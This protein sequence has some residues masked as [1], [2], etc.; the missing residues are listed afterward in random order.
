M[1]VLLNGFGKI[2][3]AAVLVE[4]GGECLGVDMVL[5]GAGGHMDQVHIVLNDLGKLNAVLQ[6]HAA[7][8][9]LGAGH[10]VLNQ[11]VV[12]ADLLDLFTYHNGE[13]GAVCHASAAFVG[14]VV[15][16]GGDELVQQP[17]VTAVEVDHLEAQGLGNPCHLSPLL[18]GLLHHLYGHFLHL[19]AVVTDIGGG[20]DGVLMTGNGVGMVH[21]ANMVELDGSHRAVRLDRLGEHHNGLHV[22]GGHGLFPQVQTVL[23]PPGI[24][25]VD[26]GLGEGDL[27]KAAARLRLI[28]IDALGSGIAV[29][30]D[31]V[32]GDGGGEHAVFEGYALD[33]HRRKHM[34]ELAARHR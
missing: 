34:G 33:G 7:L 26:E 17:A 29:V 10:A 31:P 30:H 32:G 19:H 1:N 22:E 21:G 24:L 25:M 3:V 27:G 23:M 28:N 14:T 2:Q 9:T 13:L 11:E 8:H 4:H 5:I 16:L 12:A 6:G 18:C 15:E 20:T